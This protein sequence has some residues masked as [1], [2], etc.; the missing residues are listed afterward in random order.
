MKMEINAVIVNPADNV[1]VVTAAAKAGDTVSAGGVKLAARTEVPRNHK[2]AL[3]DV[4]AGAPV[5]KYGEVIGVAS[6][7]IKA[8]EWVHGHNLKPEGV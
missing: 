1:A 6:A 8:G 5:K 2:I 3:V 4:P 7:D